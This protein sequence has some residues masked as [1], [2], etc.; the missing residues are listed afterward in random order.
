MIIK[1]QGIVLRTY[2]LRE[3]SKIAIFFTKEFGKLQGVMKG[4]RKD[5]RKF[6][7]SVDKFSLNDIVVYKYSRN[8]LHLIS[9]CDLTQYFFTIRQDYKKNVA[10]NYILELV[11]TI[12]PIETANT[13]IYDLMLEY[14]NSLDVERDIDKL[15]Y[16]FQIKV[17]LF[18]GFRPHIDSC[19]ICEKKIEGKARFSMKLGGLIC[20]HCPTSEKTFTVVSKGVVSSILYIE[21]ESWKNCLKL[22][23]TPSIKKE[24]KYILNNFLIYHLE[25]KLQT[26]KFM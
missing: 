11:N 8:D 13:S 20:A 22:G 25:K 12:M 18:S 16:I 26:S 14:L 9:E 17:L 21:Q 15:V 23:L 24:I 1:T 10:A 2:D 6:G 3:T 7:S 19:V 5:S 4:I